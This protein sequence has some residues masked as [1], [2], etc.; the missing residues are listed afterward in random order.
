MPTSIGDI[1]AVGGTNE[2]DAVPPWQ[3]I[4]FSKRGYSISRHAREETFDVDQI[5]GQISPVHIADYVLE[6]DMDEA[7]VHASGIMSPTP[8]V[9]SAHHIAVMML[10]AQTMR[11]T[12]LVLDSAF[13]Q[14]AETSFTG[15][16]SY[17]RL[18][19]RSTIGGVQLVSV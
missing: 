17:V 5:I 10:E 8:G 9:Y 11:V 16:K 3:D 15:P 14:P 12:A 1:I 13:L 7:E 6:I 19:W 2:H 18:T 4:G